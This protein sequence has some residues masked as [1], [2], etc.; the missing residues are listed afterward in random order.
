MVRATLRAL[1]LLALAVTAVA[2]V[3]P[4]ARSGSLDSLRFMAGS[5]AAGDDANR[6]EE[7]WTA[8]LGG[9]MVGMH[10]DLR[11]G[12][13]R[14]FE[15]FRIEERADGVWYL[16][17]PGGRPATAFKAK[18]LGA[19]RVVFENLEHDF[20]QRILYWR[21]KPGEIRARIE[22]TLKGKPESMEWTWTS[23]TLDR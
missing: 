23:S 16:S 2:L 10:R 5:W 11:S 14:S 22:G 18:E 8:P 3:A 21:E 17:Q 12:R 7:H 13:A 19:S 6:Q 20:P 15:F 1:A 4:P 9:M